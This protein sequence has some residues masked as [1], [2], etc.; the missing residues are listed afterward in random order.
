MPNGAHLAKLTAGFWLE[1]PIHQFDANNNKNKV[2]FSRNM[3]VCIEHPVFFGGKWRTQAQ[4]VASMLWVGWRE[5]QVVGMDS[6]PK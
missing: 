2:G 3:Q 4:D 5:K 1:N 6:F